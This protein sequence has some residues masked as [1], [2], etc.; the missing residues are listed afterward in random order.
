L[1]E[2]R[3]TDS[4]PGFAASVSDVFSLRLHQPAESWAQMK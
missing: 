2:I 3:D 4:L 1:N